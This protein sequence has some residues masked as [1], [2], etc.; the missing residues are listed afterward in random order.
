VLTNEA[1]FNGHS[2]LR[3]ASAFLVKTRDGRTVAATAK[4]LL[5][6]SGGVEPPIPLDQLNKAIKS[7]RMYPRTLPGRFVSADQLG[8]VGLDDANL[9]WLILTI[10]NGPGPLPA[11]PLRM[12][13]RPVQVG[14]QVYLVGCP[15]SE[16]ACTQDVYTGKVTARAD[17]RFRYDIE[18]PVDL[19]GFSGAPILDSNGHVA[20]VMTVWFKPKM[21][22]GDYLEGG[23]EDAASVFTVVQIGP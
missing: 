17:D 15:Y 13:A 16:A 11:T 8:C 12:R 6:S 19:R 7:W 18:P 2:Q 21:R 3:G 5:G 1:E 22:R 23:G 14:D 20:G 4:H 9:D 10:K